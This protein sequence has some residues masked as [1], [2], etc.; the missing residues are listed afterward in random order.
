MAL[1][2]EKNNVKI[3][4]EMMLLAPIFTRFMSVFQSVSRV[5]LVCHFL[6]QICQSTISL[7]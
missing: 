4:F 5:D 2:Q 3:I 7:V 1:Q 6:C